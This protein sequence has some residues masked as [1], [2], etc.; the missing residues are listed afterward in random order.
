M[1]SSTS[2][3][4][5]KQSVGCSAAKLL[6]DGMVCGMG[7]GSTARFFI[8]EVGRRMRDEGLRIIGVP[9]S[10]QSRLLCQ[11]HGIPLRDLQDCRAL[12]LAV[13]GADE[14][15]PD[16]N[17]IKGGG[18]AHTIEKLVATMASQFVI[19]VDESKLV[20]KLG[21]TIAV[22]I[23]I[24]LPALS[25]ITEVVTRLGGEPTLRMGVRKDGPV[26]TDNGHVVLDTKF[27]PHIDLREVN[28][29]LQGTPGVIGTGLF[30]D[31]ATK[32]LVGVSEGMQV[33]TL[34]RRELAKPS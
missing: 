27:A 13:D 30:F 33:K 28:A 32:V 17:V 5:L 4:A 29:R 12:D 19:I 11:Q 34:E 6:T 23:E 2:N 24:I 8:Q 20:T 31:L 10:F 21:A 22:P 18:A 3:E 25:Y 14:V 16:L 26:V 1:K 9:T 15:D 7:T